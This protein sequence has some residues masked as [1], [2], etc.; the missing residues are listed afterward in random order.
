MRIRDSHRRTARRLWLACL[1][2][3]ELQPAAVR[4]AVAALAGHPERGG[5]AVLAAFVDRLRRYERQHCARVESAVALDAATQQAVRDTCA[6]LPERIGTVEFAVNP[7][8]VAGIRAQI[9][10][11]VVDGS[12]RG[13]LERLRHALQDE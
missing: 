6:A 11:T 10:Y 13:R 8:L 1:R 9:G 4:A 2:Q 3:G 5:A 7:G 12:V